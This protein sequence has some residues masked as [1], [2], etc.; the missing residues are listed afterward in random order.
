MDQFSPAAYGPVFAE[1]LT[2]DRCR[3]LDGGAPNAAMRAALTRA[4]Q[5]ACFAHAHVVDPDMA[6]CCLAGLWLVHDFLDESHTISQNVET[7]AGSFWHGVMHRREGDFSN[8]K[9]WFRRADVP[10]VL[11][12]LGPRVSALAAE[13]QTAGV[14]PLAASGGPLDPFAFV[15]ACQ[16]ARRTSGVADAY[17]RR[18]QQLEWECLFD[19]C[20]R[21]AVGI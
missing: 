17:C 3:A 8:A 9:Y 16:A 1:L 15:D 12:E 7:S 4:T 13:A 5:A 6:Q 18:V 14:R 10:D 19:H 21:R 2:T 11:A 20:Y